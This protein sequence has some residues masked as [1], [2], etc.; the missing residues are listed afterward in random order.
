MTRPTKGYPECKAKRRAYVPRVGRP[1]RPHLSRQSSAQGPGA[2]RPR[3]TRLTRSST[4]PRTPIAYEI[5]DRPTASEILR[6]LIMHPT[7]TLGSCRRLRRRQPLPL[8]DFA[9]CPR[10]ANRSIS[11]TAHPPAVL[12]SVGWAPNATRHHMPSWAAQELPWAC[13]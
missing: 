8:A 11:T 12:R 10:G 6:L 5:T 2:L 3:K 9:G 7:R 13:R 1:N 4:T